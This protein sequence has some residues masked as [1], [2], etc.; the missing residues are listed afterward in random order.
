MALLQF[1]ITLNA[2]LGEYVLGGKHR[3]LP[4]KL[5]FISGFLSFLWF[6]VGLS[7]LQQSNIINPIF[8]GSF[9]SLLLIIYTT[10]LGVAIIWNGLIT[11]SKKEKYVMTPLTTIGFISSVF[12]L[13]YSR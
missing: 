2:P 9:T 5:K 13:I 10:F 7:Y 4:T 12:F 3:I 6:I 8:N 11:K 1:A